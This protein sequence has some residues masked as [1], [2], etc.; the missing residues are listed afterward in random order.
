MLFNVDDFDTVTA[1][2]PTP[3]IAPAAAVR[4]SRDVERGSSGHIPS[5]R[6]L[7][8]SS[9]T[10]HHLAARRLGRSWT[11][12]SQG[13]EDS[14]HIMSGLSSL[15][16]DSVEAG[17]SRPR[18]SP[19]ST[20]GFSGATPGYD[21][22]VAN[23]YAPYPY[24]SQSPRRKPSFSNHEI[25][26]H[27]FGSGRNDRTSTLPLLSS[28]SGPS[29]ILRRRIPHSCSFLL[30][31]RIVAPIAGWILGI[32]LIHQFLFPL[33]ILDT[34]SIGIPVDLN[35]GELYVPPIEND[36]SSAQWV[37]FHRPSVN[38][39]QREGDDNLDS[40]DSRWR[41]FAPL[42]PPFP[43]PSLKP[44]RFLPDHCMSD[45][46]LHGE[47]NCTSEEVGPEER[48][49]AVWFWVNGT[50]PRWLQQMQKWK[51]DLNVSTPEKHYRE[52]NELVYSI[53][54]VLAAFPGR[55]QNAHIVSADFEFNPQDVL[56]MP[57]TVL[58][59]LEST[60]NDPTLA[61]ADSTP[62]PTY[63]LKSRTGRPISDRVVHHLIT[64]WRVA[65][66]PTWLDFSKRDFSSPHH[67]FVEPSRY[68]RIDHR[69]PM[70]LKEMNY[71]FLRYATH[72]ETFHVPSAMELDRGVAQSADLEFRSDALPTF[73]SM[74]IESKVAWVPGLS[75]IVMTLNDDFFVLRGQA[76]SD[77]YSPFHGT[78]LRFDMTYG[79]QVP[80]RLDPELITEPG[81][82]GGL[83][84]ANYLLS[85]RFPDR[86]RHYAAH[87]PKV[88][89]R[90]IQNELGIM[91][92]DKLFI[93]GEKRFREMALG[94]GDI[95]TLWMNLHLRVSRC[96]IQRRD[97]HADNGGWAQIERWREALLWTYVVA[98]LGTKNGDGMWGPAA[99]RSLHDL[100][101]LQPEEQK[102]DHL[103]VLVRKGNRDT[104]K[105]RL[106]E[107]HLEQA[108]WELP[109]TTSM[110][111]SS[112]DGHV[113]LLIKPGS[114]ANPNLQCTIDFAQCFGSF[115]TKR[116]EIPAENMFKHLAFEEPECGDCMI[117]ALVSASG[118]LGLSAFFPPPERTVK[119]HSSTVVTV[120]E[121]DLAPPH[122]PLTPTW[123]EADFSI[124]NV[125][126]Q[127]A[128]GDDS[129]Q[130]DKWCMKL[131]SRYIYATGRSNARF[132]QLLGPGGAKSTFRTLDRSATLAF[133]GINDDIVTGYEDVRRQMGEWF[134]KKWPAKA[135]W[136]RG[137]DRKVHWAEDG[138]AAAV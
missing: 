13:G 101:G 57:D 58:S 84:H 76:V 17:P 36:A 39:P 26:H 77:F 98:N 35:G 94:D 5:S 130:L 117:M 70:T 15:L 9:L 18:Y 112:M 34:S 128:R 110:L 54:S 75:D 90:E 60:V 99:R 116:K 27:D 48:L 95:Q 14:H 53:R 120:D 44:T 115:W 91:F 102:D 79:M 124:Q 126:R 22:N 45:W 65:Q 55:I 46:F 63:N 33:P 28:L 136:E 129:V 119:V 137:W 121:E 106:L 56:L 3:A 71:P 31:P 73:N 114:R 10:S 43:F 12:A 103:Q 32:Y 47:T 123:Q 6:L 37:N 2:A 51:V 25:D 21:P 41:P 83:F 118:S 72:S 135:V 122:L 92:K 134:E 133:V 11:G 113:P 52:N 16:S 125:L 97:S 64:K 96:Q 40:L 50:D 23:R 107:K 78:I 42:E 105:N 61:A 89:S 111:F 85:Q 19:S 82:N 24:P 109:K 80:A 62:I 69:G 59:K 1:T 68:S 108:G 127:T 4:R 30:N 74:A 86:S 138:A 20:S 132:H 93:S 100:F 38:V 88:I 66:T 29:E 81:E 131:L 87:V 49:D 104:M 8:I 67:P 7:N